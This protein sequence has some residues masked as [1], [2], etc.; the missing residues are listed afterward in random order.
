[1]N[2]TSLRGRISPFFF[3]HFPMEKSDAIRL[4]K[5][6]Q[7][8]AKRGYSVSEI[9]RRLGVSRLF[10][11]TWN[12]A[13]DPTADERGWVKG[14]KRKYTDEQERCILD[15]RT[16]AEQGFFS[17][18]TNLRGNSVT[19]SPSISFIAPFVHTDAPNHTARK[20]KV[21]RST[22]STRSASLVRLAIA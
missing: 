4:R 17:V 3:P 16:E 15:A 5:Q 2:V 21:A 19:A 10:V 6:V 22:C 8:L 18:R 7:S 13:K 1:M 14:K 20:R 9:A 12:N 11:R